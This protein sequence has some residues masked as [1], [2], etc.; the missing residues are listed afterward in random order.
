MLYTVLV[1][2]VFQP[3]SCSRV[4]V[5]NGWYFAIMGGAV[6]CTCI[7]HFGTRSA[8]TI[9]QL[10]TMHHKGNAYPYQMKLKFYLQACYLLIP[11]QNSRELT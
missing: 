4:I 11:G 6:H 3:F 7:S 2:A 9:D 10:K 5:G 1:L 8:I